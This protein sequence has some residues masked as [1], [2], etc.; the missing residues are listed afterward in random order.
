[1]CSLSNIHG[2]DIPQDAQIDALMDW[3]GGLNTSYPPHKIGRN[4]TPN[5]RNVFVHR[6]L[7]TINKRNGF[8]FVGSTFT[9]QRISYGF[10]FNHADGSKEFMVT[11]SSVVLSTKDY[12]TYVLISSGLNFN[13]N[14][15]CTQNGYKVYCTNGVDAVFSWDGSVKVKLDGSNGTPNIPRGNYA[16]SFLNRVWIGHTGA[17]PSSLD[18]SAVVS[19]NGTILAPDNF[20]A[21]PPLNHHSVGI[22][23]GEPLTALWVYRGQ[24]QIGKQSSIYTEF[25]DRD[26]NFLDR[27]TVSQ[28]GISSHDSVVVLDGI[29]YWKGSNGI[30]A[31]NGS[32]AQ[33]ISDLI[34]PDI[35]AMKD[36]N[37]SVFENIWDT[38]AQF[39]KGNFSGSTVTAD[40]FV[41][42]N[43]QY[44]QVNSN[45]HTSVD[46]IVHS[47][48]TL[49][50]GTSASGFFPFVTTNTIPDNFLG[51]ISQDPS[52]AIFAPVSMEIW[53][54]EQCTPVTVNITV[55]I[56][57]TR[58]GEIVSSGQ[59]I[60]F[61]STTFTR[62]QLDQTNR[63]AP[64]FTADDIATGKMAIQY[65]YNDLGH[66]C[67]LTIFSATSTGFC[68]VNL[69]PST[70]GQY[71]SDV[72]TLSMVS[73]W[74]NFNAIDI[75]NRGSLKY[76]FRSSTSVVNI[77]T[78]SWLNI[79]PG[80]VL[81]APLIN[82]FI[83]WAST[84]QSVSYVSSAAIDQVTIDHIEGQGSF[85]RAFATDWNNEYWLTIST[86]FSSNFRLQYI[87]SWI[88]NPNPNAW[89]VMGG[90]NIGGIWKD[91]NNTLYGGSSSTGTVF[92]LDYGTNDNGTAIDAFY[93]T[94]QMT[95]MG[96]MF[97][98]TG[99]NWMKKQISELWVDANSENGNT[100]RLGTSVDG[101]SFSDLAFD[102]SGTGRTLKVNYT[103]NSYAKYFRW[104][105]A[106][107]QLD[108]NLGLNSFAVVYQAT[109]LR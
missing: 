11:D 108:H 57:N 27:K 77:A 87:K 10:T 63:Q 104:R 75:S 46:N 16:T 52:A 97:G 2:A 80:I 36:A 12:L 20:L 33:R 38:K 89:N 6:N 48:F 7:G 23:D 29:S 45:T 109:K 103:L 60:S 91:S 17:D 73:A 86:D 47:S 55:E 106:N 51:Y 95:L 49:P 66:N 32:A 90:M 107:S 5:M 96:Q 85:Q 88:T 24:L 83:Q 54:R 59:N 92:R 94:P 3:S 76:Y 70:T 39:I 50:A 71:V 65:S 101:G 44:F 68:N 64:L 42:I 28:A 99:G 93:E 40:G 41:T 69:T 13:S 74:G 82:N 4:F 22:G 100:L 102:L 18:W 81:N 58:T 34:V 19:T 56:K 26:S 61:D 67:P 43:N 72:A 79:S 53:G 84:I 14:L 8:T 105:F 21:W 37:S 9:L 25:G 31:Y 15:S 35:E 78:Q 1:M 30:Y 62:S 98:T